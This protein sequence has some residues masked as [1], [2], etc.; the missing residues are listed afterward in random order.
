MKKNFREMRTKTDSVMRTILNLTESLVKRCNDYTNAQISDIK[1]LIYDKV[2]AINDKE[3]E[4]QESISNFN[5]EQ[6][7]MGLNDKMEELISIVVPIY[8][9]ED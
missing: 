4:I 7:N 6:K 9:V 1:S 5:K 8:K 3:K 2:N